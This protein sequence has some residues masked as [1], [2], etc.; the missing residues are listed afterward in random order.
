MTKCMEQNH[1]DAV[2]NP[3]LRSREDEEWLFMCMK[4]TCDVCVEDGRNIEDARRTT[5]RIPEEEISNLDR[6]IGVHAIGYVQVLLH[7]PLCFEAI[8]DLACIAS[9]NEKEKEYVEKT[10]KEKGNFID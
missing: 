10:L 8:K 2:E 7:K 9:L 3:R 5:Y 1:D 6:E 4:K